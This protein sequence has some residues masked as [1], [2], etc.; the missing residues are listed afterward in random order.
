MTSSG[1]LLSFQ[2]ILF[3]AASSYPRGHDNTPTVLS[4]QS[5]PFTLHSAGNPVLPEGT[6]LRLSSSVTIRNSLPANAVPA[7][8]AVW[9]TIDHCPPC[10]VVSRPP[11]P[12]LYQ[13]QAHSKTY[14][15]PLVVVMCQ[16]CLL[17]I[18]HVG[19]C[20]LPTK[21]RGFRTLV[22]TLCSKHKI[23]LLLMLLL[24]GCPA[25][26]AK[27]RDK[28]EAGRKSCTAPTSTNQRGTTPIDGHAQRR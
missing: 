20:T 7:S 27:Q 18:V 2:S 9:L 13:A 25:F 11:Q 28:G 21:K 8:P 6:F 19:I 23:P 14:D 15:L 26:L 5:A 22:L 10:F 1:M 4:S 3:S 16:S 17:T 24:C 12:I